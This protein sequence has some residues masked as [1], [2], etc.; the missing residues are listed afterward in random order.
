MMGALLAI[1][2]VVTLI[3]IDG[4]GHDLVEGHH[5]AQLGRGGP[6][7]RAGQFPASTHHEGLSCTDGIGSVTGTGRCNCVSHR[8][9]HEGRNPAIR[10][11]R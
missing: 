4:E 7:L 3:M 8:D 5:L 9:R 6:L 2:A 11:P 10:R 1:L